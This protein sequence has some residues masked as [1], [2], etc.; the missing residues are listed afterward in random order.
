MYVHNP[1]FK[2][3]RELTVKVAAQILAKPGDELDTVA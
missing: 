3:H 1:L 2:K